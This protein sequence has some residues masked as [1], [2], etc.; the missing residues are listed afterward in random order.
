MIEGTDLERERENAC[1]ESG[2]NLH[3]VLDI[4][5]IPSIGPI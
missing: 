2:N 3:P 5:N 4:G 1:S